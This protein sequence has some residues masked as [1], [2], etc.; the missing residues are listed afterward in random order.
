MPS[1]RDLSEEELKKQCDMFENWLKEKP[2]LKS[3]SDFFN[4]MFNPE[5]KKEIK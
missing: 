1:Q 3:P 5:N 2:Q 4:E